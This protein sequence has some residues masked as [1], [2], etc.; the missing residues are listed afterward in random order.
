M[1]WRWRWVA[2]GAMPSVGGGGREDVVA[3]VVLAGGVA[4]YEDADAVADGK[5]VEMGA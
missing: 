5:V 3:G 1:G 2:I 4:A